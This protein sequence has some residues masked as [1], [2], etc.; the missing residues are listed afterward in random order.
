MYRMSQKL[1]RERSFSGRSCRTFYLGLIVCLLMVLGLGSTLHAGSWRLVASIEKGKAGIFLHYPL[2]LNYDAA[3]GRLYVADAGNNRLI[4]YTT[5]WKPLK[6]FDAAGQLRGPIGMVRERDGSLWVVERPINSLTF[7]NLKLRKVERHHLT[8]KGRPVLVDKMTLWK[9][10][11]VI[12][13]R[14]TGKILMLRKDLTVEREFAPGS[15]NFK[16]FFDLKSKGDILWGMET[17]SGRLFGFDASGKVIDTFVP[18]KHLPQPVS[19][20]RDAEG[21]VYILD[22]YMKKLLIFNRDGSLR[23][24]MLKKG[25]KPGQLSYPWEVLMVGR[26]LLILDEGNGRIDVWNR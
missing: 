6:I 22:R 20:D 18:K 21:N 12:L 9:D 15:R 17:L 4:S 25:F 2:G 26:S 14:A 13:D 5:D 16:G 3:L 24:E 8:L 1:L 10:R 23:Y 11:L 7:I 19:F